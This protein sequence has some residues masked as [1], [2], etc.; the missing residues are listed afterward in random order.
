MIRRPLFRH[1]SVLRRPAR[2]AGPA[3]LLLIAAS[4]LVPAMP[5]IAADPGDMVLQWN[6]KALAAIGNAPTA[7]PP[8]LGQAPPLA[9][10][11]LAIVQG[12]VYDAVN[13]IDGTHKPLIGHLSA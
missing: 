3:A 7:T 10:I 12:A 6:A 8:G 9:L 2:L 5:V 13:A 11:Q 1:A 4:L